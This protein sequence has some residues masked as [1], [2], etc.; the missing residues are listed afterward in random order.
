M[1][2][3]IDNFTYKSW[4]ATS[5]LKDIRFGQTNVIFGHNGAGKS[6]L[7]VGLAKAHLATEPKE[8]TRFFSGKYV[9][10]TLQLEDKS[11]IRGVVS[12]FGKKDL[13]IDKK[14]K[15][16]E[17][18]IRKLSADIEAQS[19]TVK[20][21]S[22]KTDD[23]IKEI[24][25]R[26]KDKNTKVNNKQNDKTIREKVNL[27]IKDYDDALKLFPNEDYNSIT[28][29]ADFTAE[30]ETINALTFPEIPE[31]DGVD[32]TKIETILDTEYKSVDVPSGDIVAWLDTGVHIHE[33]GRTVCEFCGNTIDISVIKQ[34]VD[35]YLNDEQHKAT[36]ALQDY[37]KTLRELHF[38]AKSLV[39]SREHYRTTLGLMDNQVKFDEMSINLAQLNAFITESIDRKLASMEKKVGGKTTVITD[40]IANIKDSLAALEQSKKKTTREVNEKINRLEVLIKGSIGLEIK[41]N[42]VIGDNLE[43]I[44]AA[45]KQ[46][47]TLKAQQDK[48]REVNDKLLA[49]KS[50]LSDFAEYLNGVLEELTL[51]FKL[52][53]AGEVYVLRHADSTALKV[54]DISDGERNLLSLIYFYYEMLADDSGKLK[55]AVKLIVI[56][57]PISSLDDGNKF[58]ITE[59]M[60]TILNQQTAQ[61]FILTHS[62]YDF[63]NIAYGF[64]ESKLSLFEIKKS[65]KISNIDSVGGKKLLPP[66]AM[67]YQE[68][69]NFRQKS[70]ITDA[71]AL[72]MPNTMRR[73]LEEY[74]KFRVGVDFATAAKTGDIAKALF[75]DELANL[76]NT[77]KQKLN[78]LLTVCNVLSHRAN[79]PKNPSEIHE[80]AK[81]LIGSI[82]RFD[83]W[84]HLKMSG[85]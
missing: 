30:S 64:D 29:N 68:A 39:D 18:Q 5:N 8:S 45:N 33:D 84:H 61:V 77:K 25:K 32:H 3:K 28:G 22:G 79:Q 47:E 24:V 56:D 75:N 35:T 21:L 71:E 76:S 58:Y 52:V 16:N 15:G 70:D 34:R 23:I 53:P 9:D 59:I 55:D 62:W 60:R 78:Q 12:N 54:D 19:D 11:G 10:S 66:Y 57:D 36:V 4:K 27:W 73:I 83:K 43:K 2:D 72:H 20:D 65:N 40:S 41:N 80:S 17:E 82:E 85:K 63:C 74:I 7:A 48:L 31:V 69:D 42:Q 44:V 14:S 50:D 51:N 37:K 46:V 67:L 49:K 6:S 13:D 1:V 81:F 26:R 38:T